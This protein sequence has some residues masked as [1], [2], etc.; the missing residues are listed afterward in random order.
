MPRQRKQP[1]PFLVL[2]NPQLQLESGDTWCDGIHP[3]LLPHVSAPRA[4]LQLCRDARLDTQ[5]RK[6]NHAA[7]FSH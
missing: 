2:S 4:S 1:W 5:V 6:T 7:A 3:L